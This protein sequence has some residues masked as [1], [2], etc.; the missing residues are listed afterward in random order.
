MPLLFIPLNSVA[1]KFYTKARKGIIKARD[2]KI[3][4]INEALQGIRQIKFAA[5]EPRWQDIIM[6]AREA[7]LAQQRLIFVWGG[8]SLVCWISAPILLGA[9]AI[10]VYAWLNGGITPAV[11]FTTLSVLTKIEG[12]LGVIPTTITEY[13]DAAVSMRRIE[14]HLKGP[15]QLESIT[16]GDDVSFDNATIAWHSNESHSS[17]FELHGVNISFP[18]GEIR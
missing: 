13:I 18:K 7:E 11:A 17:S 5:L 4:I 16:A 2:E 12:S 3:A 9:S 6:E 8:L 1:M 14:K 15:E 10:S